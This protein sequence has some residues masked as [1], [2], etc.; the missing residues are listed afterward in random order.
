MS[1]RLRF[2]CALSALV[3][4]PLLG[5]ARGELPDWVSKV[6]A[7]RRPTAARVC[8]A[9][10]YG[11]AADTLAKSTAAIQRAIDDCSAKGGGVVTFARGSYVTGALFVKHD[12][13]LRVDSGV[14]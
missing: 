10:A 1:V 2:V 11:A 8:S 5:Q 4:A 13:E 9:N 14:T 7:R 12:V 3:A 6:G